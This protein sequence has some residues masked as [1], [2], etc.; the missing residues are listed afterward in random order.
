VY[1]AS[2]EH[3]PLAEPFVASGEQSPWSGGFCPLKLV[4]FYYWSIRLMLCSWVVTRTINLE[5]IG[6]GAKQP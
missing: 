1:M 3:K 4:A 6:A 5:K 2:A